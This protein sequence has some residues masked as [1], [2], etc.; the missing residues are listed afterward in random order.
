M[1]RFFLFP[2]FLLAVLISPSALSGQVVFTLSWDTLNFPTPQSVQVGQTVSYDFTIHNNTQQT[3]VGDI[4]L[5]LRLDTTNYVMR[6]LPNETIPAFTSLPTNFTDTV[7][8]ARYSG[9]VNIVVIWPTAVN[10]TTQ[11]TISGSITVT[12]VSAQG[13][14][15]DLYELEAFPN[16]VSN[17]LRLRYDRPDLVREV[18]LFDERG[19]LL[20]RA[21]GLPGELDLSS[22]AAGVYFLQ[23]R[24]RDGGLQRL[25]V[26]KF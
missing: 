12:G 16:P 13:P 18:V 10:A 9:G 7:Q 22:L 6:T 11:D 15:V 21:Q 26:L 14:N 19:A 1:K 24:Y 20:R 25:K 3:F 8:L 23:V 2:A 4:D 5:I 17:G